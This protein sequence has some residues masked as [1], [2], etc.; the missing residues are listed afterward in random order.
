MD[1]DEP[2]PPESKA[3]PVR[4]PLFDGSAL[5]PA[6]QLPWWLVAAPV[7]TKKASWPEGA[8]SPT[9][10]DD[11][12]K[13]KLKHAQVYRHKREDEHGHEARVGDAVHAALEWAAAR[14]I[15]PAKSIPGT[16]SVAELLHLVEFFGPASQNG[17]VLEGARE[18]LAALGDVQFGKVLGVESLVQLWL[19]PNVLA[20]GYYDVSR[21][22]AED[23]PRPLIVAT[24]YKSGQADLP[25]EAELWHSLK[26]P[27]YMVALK[28][29]HPH[30]RVRGRLWN[31][32]QNEE[33]VIDY[34]PRLEREFLARARSLINAWTKRDET[35]TVGPHCAWCPF[36]V[37]CP[38]HQKTV[39]AA[40]AKIPEGSLIG[41]PIGD[42]MHAYRQA[43]IAVDAAKDTKSDAA[44]LILAAMGKRQR[45]HRTSWLLATKKSRMRDEWRAE[46]EALARM[47]EA[48][49]TPIEALLAEVAEIN[50]KRIMGWINTLPVNKQEAAR[51]V[52]KEFREHK[53]GSPWVEVREIKESTE[54]F[55]F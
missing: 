18:L 48:T 17:M 53:P 22:E 5:A 51:A 40:T 34:S 38:E 30:A 31:V 54:S 11:M 16:A 39:R 24:D 36:R 46:G 20:A 43:K 28:R 55:G 12:A 13:C 7:E 50:D 14:R 19:S 23:T 49:E 6:D 10:L 45:T 41:K 35:A 47:A 9:W 27:F 42:L 37:E 52:A 26:L 1:H 15:R 32:R 44:D 2:D 4:A 33:V 21:I 3:A 29:L 25:D 8:Y